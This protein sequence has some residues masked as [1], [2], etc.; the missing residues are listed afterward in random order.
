MEQGN[1][2]AFQRAFDAL[3]AEEQQVVVEA[4]QYL[5]G[6]QE[7][8]EGDD[9]DE[10]PEIADVV[11]QFEPLLQTIAIGAGDTTHR[12][13]I[14]KTLAELETNLEIENWEFSRAVQR[15]WAGERDVTTL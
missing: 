15:I 11:Q 13:E 8:E 6:Q 7:E 9:E 10:E 2:A 5:Q 4:M 12:G 1:Q 3:S 14:M